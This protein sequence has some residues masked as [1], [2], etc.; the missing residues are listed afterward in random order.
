MIRTAIVP[1]L[2][3]LLA[4]G[5]PE[6]VTAELAPTPPTPAAAPAAPPAI[7]ELPRTTGG[8]LA[9]ALL[10]AV[11]SDDAQALAAFMAER[12][13]EKGRK[14]GPLD[15]WVQY[16]RGLGGVSG[17]VDVVRVEPQLAGSNDIAFHVRARSADRHVRVALVI[18]ERGGLADGFIAPTLDP[19]RP[20]EGRL[21]EVVMDEPALARAIVQRAAQLAAADRFSGVVLVARGD[22]VL[23]HVAHGQAEQ[24]FA[25]DNR[26]DTRFNLGSMNKMF[27]AVAV[28]QL[29]EQGK[30]SFA[31]TVAEVLPDYT[32]REFAAR[33]T[34][35]HLLTH[36][37]GIGG[38]IFAPAMYEHRD[39]YKTPAD[40]IPLFAGVAPDFPPGTRFSYANPGF[41]V[42]GRIV[43]RVSG[44]PYDAYVQRHIFDVAGMPD[45]RAHAWDELTPNLA[46]G[47]M[48]DPNDAFGLLPRRTNVSTL[49]YSGTPAGGGY[50]TAP[51]LLAFVRALRGHRLLGPA[52]LAAVLRGEVDAPLLDRESR[53]GY[54]FFV[55]ELHGKQLRG[56]A[57]GAPGI[58]SHLEFFAD[59]DGVVAVLGNHDSPNAS[60]LATEILALLAAQPT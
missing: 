46:V 23:V 50:S 11:N 14:A 42:L 6:P 45:T 16:F 32:D 37:S 51:D 59:G 36:T 21:P 56:H 39:R 9:R 25:A 58:N 17:G 22:R 18:D 7:V 13:S 40:Y 10:D 24:A 38:T 49:P 33:A 29:V 4:C 34:V 54:G 60:A 28:A 5:R 19:T 2:S 30:L 52:T 44:E 48:R 41:I 55:R 3:A 26:L 31:T 35:H 12:L 57:G 53:Y 47:Y 8:A 27:T 20:D 1:L 43:E 15:E